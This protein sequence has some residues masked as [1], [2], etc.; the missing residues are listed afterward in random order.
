MKEPRIDKIKCIQRYVQNYNILHIRASWPMLR[1][2]C[3]RNVPYVELLGEMGNFCQV[4]DVDVDVDVVVLSI[5]T[6]L[7]KLSLKAYTY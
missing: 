7:V 4:Y 2:F 6:I 3:I 1:L 5:E